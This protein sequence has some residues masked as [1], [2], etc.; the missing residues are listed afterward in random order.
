MKDNLRIAGVLDGD[1]EI[2][3]KAVFDWGEGVDFEIFF[4]VTFGLDGGENDLVEKKEGA[5]LDLT[6]GIAFDF[7]G[8][9]FGV[10]RPNV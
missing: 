7:L 3:D 2:I 9:G 10:K 1:D 4:G 6:I 5:H 8:V